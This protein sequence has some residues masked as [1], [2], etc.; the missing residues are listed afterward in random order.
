MAPAMPR[1]RRFV[2][3]KV[4]M[5]GRALLLIGFLIGV[6]GT[7]SIWPLW[8]DYFPS[9]IVPSGIPRYM[10]MPFV[11]LLV[12]CVGA[13]LYGEGVMALRAEGDPNEPD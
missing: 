6:T 1:Q 3:G 13:G 5:R 10:V 4:T 7:P 9:S 12:I 8:R 11:G 2:A